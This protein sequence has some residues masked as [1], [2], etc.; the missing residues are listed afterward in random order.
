MW[1]LLPEIDEV[2]EAHQRMLAGLRP[3]DHA[4]LQAHLRA[5]PGLPIRMAE[6]L[7]DAAMAEGL[8]PSRRGR[9]RLAATEA[10]TRLR[11]QPPALLVGEYLDKA[12]RIQERDGGM[13]ATQR[14]LAARMGE[15]AFWDGQAWAE[16]EALA[17]RE[18]LA[19]SGGGE[20][21]SAGERASARFARRG[22]KL[23]GWGVLVGG[24]SA[25]I[26]SAGAFEGVFGIT[27]GVILLLV[28]LLTLIVSVLARIGE[29]F[30]DS[31]GPASEQQERGAVAP[32]QASAPPE[33]PASP[34]LPP[35]T[36]DPVER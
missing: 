13:G 9:L 21:G 24:A 7:D 1:R 28:G 12:R 30:E 26:V 32:V 36:L 27:V 15:A 14:A 29:S 3:G 18:R 11:T 4:R 25:L 17:W 20:P 35:A 31:S 6:V 8:G 34:A 5:D 19:G 2:M 23:L 16:R 33:P 22:A 10:G